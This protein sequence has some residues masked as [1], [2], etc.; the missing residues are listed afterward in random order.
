ML[1]TGTGSEDGQ[2]TGSTTD[3][4]DNLVLEILRVVHD[5][6]LVGSR[7]DRVLQH[8]FVDV[9]RGVGTVVVVMLITVAEVIE[10]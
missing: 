1:G 7:A 10:H 5:S 2:N 3:V 8:L 6:S 4:H 9:E